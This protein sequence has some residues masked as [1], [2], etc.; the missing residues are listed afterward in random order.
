M[1]AKSI[2]KGPKRPAY[3]A[4]QQ[5]RHFYCSHVALKEMGADKTQENNEERLNLDSK[6][7]RSFLIVVTICGNIYL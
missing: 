1:V 7:R 4:G 3:S 5:G 6:F 2:V